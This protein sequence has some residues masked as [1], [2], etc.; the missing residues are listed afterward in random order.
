MKFRQHTRRAA[1]DP[2]SRVPDPGFFVALKLKSYATS[3][4]PPSRK[5]PVKACLALGADAKEGP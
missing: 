3:G 1:S 4:V 5:G 2:G